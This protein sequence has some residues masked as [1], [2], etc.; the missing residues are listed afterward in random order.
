MKGLAMTGEDGLLNPLS[1]NAVTLHG[2]T[3]TALRGTFAIDGGRFRSGLFVNRNIW[4]HLDAICFRSEDS[5]VD[6][7]CQLLSLGP[8]QR[9][10]GTLDLQMC[11]AQIPQDFLFDWSPNGSERSHSSILVSGQFMTSVSISVRGNRSGRDVFLAL[12]A[13]HGHAEPQMPSLLQDGGS[14]ELRAELKQFQIKPG[15]WL[16][17]SAVGNWDRYSPAPILENEVLKELSLGDGSN[18]T[19][20]SNDQSL[21]VLLQ[22]VSSARSMP[23]SRH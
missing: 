7:K 13:T 11:G 19:I 5:H 12:V 23:S 10:R 15:L 18:V 14:D 1:I 17:I 9:G 4:G 3:A 21:D 2:E 8:S 16:V 22:F 6:G 20:Q